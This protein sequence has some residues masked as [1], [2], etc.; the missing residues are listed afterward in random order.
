MMAA[1]LEAAGEAVLITDREGS[2]LYVNPA[3]EEV[4]GYTREEAVGKNPRILKS[5]KHEQGLYEAMWNTLLKGR[6]WKGQIINR[7][8][9]GTL[10][11]VEQTLAPVRTEQGE[12]RYFAAIIR[13]VTDRIRYEEEL[14][15]YRNSLEELVEE[16]TLELKAANQ[17]LEAFSFSVSHDLR[18]PLRRIRGFVEML[19]E[20]Y[21]SSLEEEVR[22]ILDRIGY[23]ADMMWDLINDLIQLSHISR[24]NLKKIEVDLSR[25]AEDVLNELESVYPRCKE[26]AQVEEGMKALGDPSLLRIVFLNLLDN[27]LKYTSKIETPRIW[28]GKNEQNEF[29]VKDNGAGFDMKYAGRLFG[30]FQRLHGPEEF[31]GNGIGLATVQRI[32]HK[33]GGSIRALGKPDEGAQFFF[34]LPA[35]SS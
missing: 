12:I 28:L 25:L 30:P 7:K 22:K 19:R 24:M 8:K 2:I 35:Y 5:G 3:F 16:R 26:I 27:S 31:E 13:D 4:T 9:D 29:F 20:D 32:I 10:F 33:H 18:A 14:A 21:P 34:S 1:A 11:Q 15:F 17:E 6:V 23:S